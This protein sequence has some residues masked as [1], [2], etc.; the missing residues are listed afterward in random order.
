MTQQRY[1]K[2]AAWFEA[3]PMALSALKLLN[4]WLPRCLYLAYPVLLLVLVFFRD[5]RILKVLLIP[6]AVFLIVT[7]LRKGIHAKRPYE[8]LNI[9]PLIQKDKKGE[10]FPSRHV[11]SAFI[12][13]LA[14]LYVNIPLGIITFLIAFLI[15]IIRPLAGIHFP[16]DVIVGALLSL[17]L[18][19]PAFWF[20]AF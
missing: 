16:R 10:S 11:A 5:G 18:G 17:A 9:K 12:L 4:R 2:I 13:A 15:A 8:Q 19:I 7:L 20:L 3:R 14:F 1:L 6:A